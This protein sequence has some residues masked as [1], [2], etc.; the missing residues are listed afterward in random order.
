MIRR[1][2]AGAGLVFAHAAAAHAAAVPA[3]V[4]AGERIA[5]AHCGECHAL[6]RGRS[7][8]ADAPP[9]RDLH[10]RYPTGGGLADLLGEGMIAPVSPQEEGGA[11]RHPRMPQVKLDDAQIGELAAYLEWVQRPGRAR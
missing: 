8:L 4:A 7:P 6:G 2:L 1:I 9:F 3:R 5:R 11:R 10:Q